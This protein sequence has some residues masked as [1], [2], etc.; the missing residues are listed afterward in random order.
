MSIRIVACDD[1]THITRTVSMKLAKAGF[2]VETA[3]DGLAAW[4]AIQREPPAMLITDYQMPRLD[5]L[6]LCRLLRN[7]PVTRA[8]PVI[9]L[10]AK[11]FEL[12]EER[13][14][15]QMRVDRVISK[16]FSPRDLLA[17]VEEILC[18]T[19]SHA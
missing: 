18:V 9:L 6:G 15:T 16:P 14:V 1:E 11:G 10:T 8:L 19:A 3:N 4:E 5:G 12:D 17:T 7:T 2:I 13:I